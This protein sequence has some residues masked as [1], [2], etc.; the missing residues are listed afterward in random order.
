MV[1]AGVNTGN[2][3]TGEYKY[4]TKMKIT[5]KKKVSEKDRVSEY[6]KK[7]CKKFPKLKIAVNNYSLRAGQRVNIAQFANGSKSVWGNVN[8]NYMYL[9][10]AASDPNE[11]IKLEEILRGIPAGEAWL[12]AF[13]TADNTEVVAHGTSIDTN[14]EASSW[15]ALRMPATKPNDYEDDES[16]IEAVQNKNLKL[17]ERRE[18]GETAESEQ[19][20]NRLRSEMLEA[21]AY[22]L[23]ER[24]QN[25]KRFLEQEIRDEKKLEEILKQK[26][27]NV[28]KYQQELD[29]I[30]SFDSHR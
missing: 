25:E 20:Q 2:I 19:E 7:L 12:K 23:W 26:I 18:K 10:K 9:K 28:Q 8:L 4:D 27:Q 14:G 30:S 29:E 16:V 21:S 22:D 3:N 1:S 6:Y 15:S 13:F 24:R 5:Q 17:I 11:A